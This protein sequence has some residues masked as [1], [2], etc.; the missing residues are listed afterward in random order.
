MLKRLYK[1]YSEI[2]KY[3]FF[4]VITTAVNL[5]AFKIFDVILGK[6]LFLV[7]N[8]IAWVIAVAFAYVSNKLWVFESK[9]WKAAL[10]IKELVGFLGA[11]LFSLGA[12]ELGLWLMIDLMKMGDYR[13][14]DILSFNVDGNFIAKLIMQIVVVILNYVFSKFLIFAK[15]TNN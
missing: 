13:G 12:E 14:F 3:V 8:V 5:A 11:R 15:K 10:V 9:S 1:K 7:T 2:I 4:G 6:D